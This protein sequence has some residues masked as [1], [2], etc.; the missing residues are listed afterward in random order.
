[1]HYE[2]RKDI[3]VKRTNEKL[4][5]DL[6]NVLKN[7]DE[8]ILVVENNDVIIGYVKFKYTTKVTK[9]IWID[10][11]IIDDDYKKKGY[12][13]K[14]IKEVTK[15]AEKNN[16]KRIELNC[17]FF[18]RDALKFYEKLGLYN[19]ELYLKKKYNNLFN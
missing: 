3:F 13:K 9:S 15:F 14:L 12:G 19:K 1:M 17:W 18:N 11:I 2:N 8:I 7:L 10:E 4:R 16:C 5:K 6:I